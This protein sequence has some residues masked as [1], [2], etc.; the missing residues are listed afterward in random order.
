M[1]SATRL[2]GRAGFQHLSARRAFRVLK[3]TML[4]DDQR[5]SQ[6][7]HHQDAKQTA[8]CGDQHYPSEFEIEPEYENRRHGDA[9]S[10]SNRLPC[11][12][13][14]LHDVVLKDGC[15]AKTNLR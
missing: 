7:N 10:E 11:R 2:I 9:E 8:E 1:C 4:S 5:A 3:I 15:V 13:C 6:W 12:A 14:R